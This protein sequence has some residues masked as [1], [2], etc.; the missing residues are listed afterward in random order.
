MKVEYEYTYNATN[1]SSTNKYWFGTSYKYNGDNTF[2]VGGD[3]EQLTLIEYQTANKNNLY[4]CFSTTS[5]CNG[6]PTVTCQ[7]LLKVR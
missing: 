4:I 3:V 6:K 5:D 1:L 2:S 7:R